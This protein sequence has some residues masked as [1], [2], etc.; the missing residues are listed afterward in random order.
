MN[1]ILGKIKSTFLQFKKPTCNAKEVIKLSLW[2]AGVYVSIGLLPFINSSL[3]MLPSGLFLVLLLNFIAI[4][5]LSVKTYF[6]FMA[7]KRAFL[8][9][10]AFQLITNAIHTI[11]QSLF[12]GFNVYILVCL[13]NTR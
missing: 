6:D 1:R 12:I 3:V 4:F 8:E 7:T 9:A 5:Y 10:K 11:N 2:I 13:I